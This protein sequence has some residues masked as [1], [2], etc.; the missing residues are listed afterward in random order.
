MPTQNNILT[1][2][3]DRHRLAS[4]NPAAGAKR[5][6]SQPSRRWIIW[7]TSIGIF[8]PYTFGE[9]GKYVI[10][11]LFLTT[12]HVL[13]ISISQRKRQ[14][15]G[16]DI[17]VW[18]AAIWMVAIKIGS[19]DVLFATCSE[20]LAFVGSYMLARSAFYGEPAVKEFVRALK[21]IAIILIALSV[22]DTLTGTFF[23]NSAVATFF[24]RPVLRGEAVE[25]H[26]SL[27]G[28]VVLR[29]KLVFP[30][31]ILFGTF[32]SVAAAIFLYSEQSMGRRVFYC[33]ICFIG[34]ILSISSA[35]LLG[36]ALAVSIYLYDQFLQAYSSRWKV[37]L[38]MLAAA[39]CAS[40]ALSNNPLTWLLRHA[41]LDPADAYYRLLIWQNAFEYIALSPIT[42]ADPA[43]WA[44]D[45]ILGNS[46]DCVWLVLSLGYGLPMV[47]LVLL[48]SLSACGVFG[49]KINRR[50]VNLETLRT[51][52]GFSL[53]LFLFAFLGLTVH[54]WGAMWMLWGLCIGIRASL[55][56]YCLAGPLPTSSPT[57]LQ[58]RLAGIH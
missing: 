42:G 2:H 54:F 30:H 10:A 5:P 28:F 29:A 34:C 19:P 8:L 6:S 9:T 32:C 4:L 15:M 57:K 49:R 55:E 48:A 1:R 58:P 41:T 51:R 12:I 13:P 21:L 53:V 45:E 50:L 40:F 18:A 16:C 33:G 56:E 43:S 22:L 44:S 36:F 17:F 7:L 3:G 24:P 23:T 25:I 26:R 46:I 35:P 27:F 38:V 37:L 20:A 39:F 31:P 52:T 14:L 11:L 47:A